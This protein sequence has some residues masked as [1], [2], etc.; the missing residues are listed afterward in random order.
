VPHAEP[1]DGHMAGDLVAGQHP[2]G[3][4]LVAAP[5]DL[6]GGAHPDGIAVHQHPKQ[7]LGVVGGLAV[8]VSPRGAQEQV[9]VELVD[10]IAHEPGEV[11][12]WQPVA[13]VRGQQEGLVAVAANEVVGHDACYRFA[14]FI[15]NANCFLSVNSRTVVAETLSR[16]AACGRHP[17]PARSATAPAQPW[18]VGPPSPVPA[19]PGIARL[20][21]GVEASPST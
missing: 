11:I 18:P 2:E 1:R 13:Q 21:R 12:G 17:G 9:E 5:L 20:L 4:V 15:P 10:H 14:V 7:R 16:A 8:P 3:E 19:P 6:P